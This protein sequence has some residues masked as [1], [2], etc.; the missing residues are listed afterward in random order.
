[1]YRYKMWVN[2]L[3][4]IKMC[5]SFHMKQQM[6]AEIHLTNV[7]QRHLQHMFV[8]LLMNFEIFISRIKCS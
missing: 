3:K 1:M 5:C 2:G 8:E 6:I 4:H 7:I